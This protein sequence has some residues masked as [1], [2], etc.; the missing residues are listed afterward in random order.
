MNDRPRRIALEQ[1]L[2]VPCPVLS[3]VP[4][5]MKISTGKS[6]PGEES[7]T[8]DVYAGVQKWSALDFSKLK[9]NFQ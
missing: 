9:V 7:G 4:V 3:I 2:T 8:L 5:N 1:P 6:H